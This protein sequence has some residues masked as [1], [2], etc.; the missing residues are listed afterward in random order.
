MDGS[1]RQFNWVRHYKCELLRMSTRT[2]SKGHL[3]EVSHRFTRITTDLK[4]GLLFA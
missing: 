2:L 4:K 3:N 1:E